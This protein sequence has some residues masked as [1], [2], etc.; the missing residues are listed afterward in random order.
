MSGTAT[1]T[2]QSGP[3]AHIAVALDPATIVADGQSTTQAT[4]TLGDAADQP[5]AGRT[6]TLTSDGDQTIGAVHDNGD[7]T[8]T[9]TI[10][11]STRAGSDTITATTGS[12]S[13]TAELK[14]EHGPLA[15]VA[16]TLD[17]DTLPG[18]GTDTS[19][20]T[21]TVTDA[22]GNPIAGQ[23]VGWSGLA[24]GSTDNGDGTYTSAVTAPP[25][26]GRW[27]VTVHV[28]GTDIEDTAYLTTTPYPQRV[29][30]ALDDATLTADG[31]S[32]TTAHIHL[33]EDGSGDI[34]GQR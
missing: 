6:V 15:K 13:S 7:G 16:L 32:T 10:T 19:T 29:A 17:P 11:S 12:L 21:A 18:N 14:Q 31:E 9:A 25:H 23:L 34:P 30:M 22:H 4:V 24:H 33:S 5:A 28:S 3:P 1:L 8:Y 27:A 20:A 2:E 26:S